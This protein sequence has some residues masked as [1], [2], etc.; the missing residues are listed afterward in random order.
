MAIRTAPMG[1]AG[2]GGPAPRR[3]RR[4]PC[5]HEAL[6]PRVF[7]AVNAGGPPFAEGAGRRPGAGS[8]PRMAAADDVAF[9]EPIHQS[10]AEAFT[11]AGG[12]VGT[13]TIVLH[14][15]PPV[16]FLGP[17]VAAPPTGPRRCGYGTRWWPWPPCPVCWSSRV[18]RPPRPEVPGVA[19]APAAGLR[20]SRVMSGSSKVMLRVMVQPSPAEGIERHRAKPQ[21]LEED[22]LLAAVRAI[23][24]LA[25]SDS[26]SGSRKRPGMTRTVCSPRPRSS[27]SGAGSGPWCRSSSGS[28]GGLVGDHA[29]GS[30]WS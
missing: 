5:F 29:V 30:L 10:M 22:A 6:L 19:P 12:V 11:A 21:L 24:A 28:R 26:P 2:D 13:R 20:R 1:D 25:D 23:S 9:H 8:P 15:D 14:Q 16:G 18:P 27:G 7:A 3:S 17:V 4:R